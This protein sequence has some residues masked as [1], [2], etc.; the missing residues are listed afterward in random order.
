[1]EE[2]AE[3]EMGCKSITSSLTW[4]EVFEDDYLLDY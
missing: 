4:Q 3:A 2:L 1:M